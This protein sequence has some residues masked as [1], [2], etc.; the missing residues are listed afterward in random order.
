VNTLLYLLPVCALLYTAPKATTEPQHTNLNKSFFRIGDQ[1]ITLEK[2][3]QGEA[4]G[5]V[6][7]SLHSDEM[8]AIGTT[9]DFVR[10]HNS[11]FLRLV[12][13]HRRLVEA[14]FYDHKVVFDPNQVFTTWGRRIELREN[15][16]FDKLTNL[17]VLQFSRFVTGEIRR[18]KTIVSI[19]NTEEN[20]SI[21]QY[22]PGGH[23]EKLA[24]EVYMNPAKDPSDFMVTGEEYIY[25]GLKA[26][27]F[28]VVF[29]HRSRME[30][31]GSLEVYCSKANQPYVIME[32]K[33]GHGEEQLRM[34]EVV[35]GMLK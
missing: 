24:K 28:N 11:V 2:Y 12:N 27:G 23:L 15:E 33:R 18:D 35:D 9:M 1:L 30:D 34:M 32:V 13:G 21:R 20:S 25:N 17:R 5:Y 14:D 7:V 31:N 16:C 26:Q 6:L 19:H 10:Q 4:P 3:S 29:L 8:D 22:L